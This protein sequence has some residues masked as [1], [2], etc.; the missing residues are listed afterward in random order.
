MC[1]P[2]FSRNRKPAFLFWISWF[3][4]TLCAPPRLPAILEPLD[5]INWSQTSQ[6]NW[7]LLIGAEGGLFGLDRSGRVQRLWEGGEVRKIVRAG[8]AWALLSGQGILVSGDLLKWENRSG[9]LPVKTI[10]L[11]EEGI[12]SF[13][14][15]V[16]EIKDLEVNPSNPEIMTCAT[17]DTVYL[18]RNG[19][20]SWES[21]GMPS[22]RT[23]GIKAV[24]AAYLPRGGRAAG[25]GAGESVEMAVFLSHSI[26]GIHYLIP[27]RAGAKWT[28]MN[29]GVETLETTGNADEVADIAVIGSAPGAVQE[30]YISQT[31]RHRIYRLDWA[32]KKFTL[33]WADKTPFGTVDSLS[34]SPAG[35]RFVREG[36]VA[37]LNYGGKGA[38]AGKSRAPI[39]WDRAD[40]LDILRG[41]PE[42]L[43]LKPNS[44]V[45]QDYLGNGDA[46]SLNEL[47]L[48]DEYSPLS[49]TEKP[50][51][52]TAGSRSP[53]GH[54]GLYLP[55]NH[56]MASNTLQ[57][58]L[59]VIAERGL[60][61][62]VIDMK[63]D[64]GRLRF[65]PRDPA[66]AEKGRVFRPLDIDSFLKDMKSR[67]IY[68][69]ARIV[70][71]KD[72]VLA[73]KEGGRYAVWD[74]S[75]NKAW[76]G[77]YDRRR[78]KTTEEQRAAEKNSASETAILP[79]S[80][81]EFEILR[82]WYDER[83]VDPYSELVWDYIARVAR[84]L[85]ERGF[86]EIQFD[87][88]RFPTD[89]INLGNA[90][91]R[92]RDQGMDMESAIVSFL[93][94]I[95]SRLEAPLSIDIYGANGWYRTGA[96]TGQEVELLSRYVDV[97]CPMYYPSHF[98]QDFLAQAPAEQRPYRIYFLGT[99]RTS[100]VGRGRVLV[101]P[102]VQ[103]FY[104]NVSYDRR[105]YSPA[106]VRLQVEGVRDAGN[107]GLTYWN[108]SGR[109]EDIPRP[110]DIRTSAPGP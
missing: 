47:W 37:E 107:P 19:G 34:P 97:I 70:V 39:C 49:G 33:Q 92:W 17:K 56:A 18:S 23:N 83:W 105:Y 48:L 40:I 41:I 76:A 91:Y 45:I 12:K 57:P 101:R 104:L 94:H 14:P 32:G 103:A 106:Y 66:I 102:Y 62:V 28:E 2:R 42:N 68:T 87:Y 108:N 44:V 29:G 4:L 77:Y 73:A 7:P 67:G 109:Y 50:G 59:N 86:D 110:A 5:E 96:R 85:H 74:S 98:E 1:L 69:A 81:P 21:L 58:Y 35:L 51:A 80:D 54:D 63:D 89:G 100:R 11:Y 9:G 60:D 52:G 61:M 79:A 6:A 13:V 99:Q 65:T 27:G 46:V 38:E 15:M 31:F 71:F 95:R 88:I 90:R 75:T 82:T 26:Y 10:K 93:R 8:E 24:A 72:P 64:Y 78:K 22:Y 30:V 55:V 25:D 53:A 3:C 36:M 20:R 43:D 16:Q 84:E